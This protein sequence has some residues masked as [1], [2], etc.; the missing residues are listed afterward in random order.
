MRTELA[1]L[2]DAED[3]TELSDR[4]AG[5]LRFG[6]AG[7]RGPRGAGPNRMNRVVVMRAAAGV[8]AWLQEHH[9]DPAAV[10]GFDARHQSAEFAADAAAVLAGA[11]VRVTLM[12]SPRPTPVL[13]FAV[14]HLGADAGLMLTASHN[15]AAD[16]GLKVYLGDTAQIADPVDAEIA[17][18][19][20]MLGAVSALPKSEAYERAGDDLLANYID[21]VARPITGAGQLTVVYT[22]L[23]GVGH[24]AFHRVAERCGFS[25]EGVPEQCAP[26]PDFPTVAFPNPEEPGAMDAA[27]D[28]ADRRSA[29]LVLAHDPDADRCALAARNGKELTVLTGDEL[30]VLLADAHLRRGVSGCY[31]STIVSSELLGKMAA[32]HGQ[33][34]QQTLTGFKW[35]GRIP[36]LAFG[37]E[38]A[39]GYCVSPEVSRD[40][41]GIAAA[42]A[43]V[44]LV[45]ELRSRGMTVFDRLDEIQREHGYHLTGQ[46]AL[47]FERPAEVVELMHRLRSAPPGSLGAYP[48]TSLDDFAEGY[49]DLPQTDALRLGLDG[50]RVII[51]PSGTE[52]KVKCYVEVVADDRTRAQEQLDSVLDQLTVAMAIGSTR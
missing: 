43:A 48:V 34:W 18:G 12:D 47:R 44:E 3:V 10:V 46:L 22:A 1:A 39:L 16:S 28:L 52:P 23:H 26:D 8:A 38:E 21:A 37:Y 33:R 40:K 42:V 45:A 17:A 51:R 24:D 5:Y 41:D 20:E 11:G 2:I 13:A 36:D 31:A 9:E 29:D 15:R 25:F 14:G 32:A 49:R 7:L 50:G 27:L 35:V 4:F 30:G 19:I 6:T